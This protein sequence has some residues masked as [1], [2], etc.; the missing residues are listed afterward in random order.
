[1]S[2][3]PDG[4]FYVGPAYISPLEMPGSVAAL[5]Q[6]LFHLQMTWSCLLWV[7]PWGWE[8]KVGMFNREDSLLLVE[9]CVLFLTLG[10]HLSSSEQF[11]VSVVYRCSRLNSRNFFQI[12]IWLLQKTIWQLR[13]EMKWSLLNSLRGMLWPTHLLRSRMGGV[14]MARWGKKRFIFLLLL[15][16]WYCLL[17]FQVR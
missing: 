11:S 7:S 9:I 14:R 10:K 16:V 3:V 4:G 13:K 1:M 6:P 12:V 5:C 15:S 17:S 2:A 8:V